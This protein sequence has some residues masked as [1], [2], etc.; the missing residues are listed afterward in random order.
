MND[1]AVLGLVDELHAQQLTIPGDVAVT[2]IVSSARTSTMTTPPLAGWSAPG[3]EMGALAV[4]T[5]LQRIESGT[6]A[7]IRHHLVSCSRIP[8]DSIPSPASHPAPPAARAAG[9]DTP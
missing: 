8:G 6:D 7:P 1:M 5:L 3:E 9:T 4:E 2:T